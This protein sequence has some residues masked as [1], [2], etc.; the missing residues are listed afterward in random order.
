MTAHSQFRGEKIIK[1]CKRGIIDHYKTKAKEAKALDDHV[2]YHDYLQHIEG[3][4]RL[5]T[6]VF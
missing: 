6:K 4:R 1:R 2:L 5:N 3:W